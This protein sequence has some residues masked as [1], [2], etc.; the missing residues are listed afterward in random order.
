MT[1][2]IRN[3]VI[4]AIIELVTRILFYYLWLLKFI[5]ESEVKGARAEGL[6]ELFE[7]RNQTIAFRL[8]II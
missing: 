7:I 8:L 6:H 4:D 3:R 5:A 2:K 1:F